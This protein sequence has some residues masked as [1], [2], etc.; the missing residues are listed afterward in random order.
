MCHS[1]RP[2]LFFGYFSLSQRK[3]PHKYKNYWRWINFHIKG[4]LTSAATL[5]K[6]ML[7]LWSISIAILGKWWL[8]FLPF[9]SIANNRFHVRPSVLIVLFYMHENGHNQVLSNRKNSQGTTRLR[10]QTYVRKKS[11]KREYLIVDDFLE[12]FMEFLIFSYYI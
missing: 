2:W 11:L 7:Q 10:A 3:S 12:H 8:Y 9:Q 6:C 4:L 5:L 1:I